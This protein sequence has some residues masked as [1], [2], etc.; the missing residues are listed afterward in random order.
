[1][2]FHVAHVV[3]ASVLG[4]LA[5]LCSQE[6]KYNPASQPHPTQTS[7]FRSKACVSSR[8][9]F[10]L[11]MAS[12]LWSKEGGRGCPQEH[13]VWLYPSLEYFS[14]ANTGTFKYMCLS[15]FSSVS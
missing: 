2:G 11:L 10:L 9:Q 7:F 8:P 5:L 4:Q 1:M 12:C 15:V 6:G 13:S 3:L 14:S